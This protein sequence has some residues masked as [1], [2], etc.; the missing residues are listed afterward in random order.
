MILFA[1]FL[2]L[3]PV[4]MVLMFFHSFSGHSK[5]FLSIIDYV[6]MGTFILVYC[7]FEKPD[8]SGG[9]CVFVVWQHQALAK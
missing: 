7:S 6:Y 4:D 1:L 8:S 3:S 5:F 2:T 9:V